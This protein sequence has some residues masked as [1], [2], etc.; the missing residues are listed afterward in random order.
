MKGKSSQNG[1]S[2]SDDLSSTHRDHPKQDSR[3]S[4]GDSST[5]SDQPDDTYHSSGRSGMKSTDSESDE[6]ETE[7]DMRISSDSH[8][9]V[10]EHWI[11]RNVPGNSLKGDASSK[12]HR[13]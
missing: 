6:S 7:D 4:S 3:Q 9:S 1:N 11:E 13:P 8:S 12:S 2:E 5:E 10:P